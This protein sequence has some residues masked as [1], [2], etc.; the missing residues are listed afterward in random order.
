[1]AV[2]SQ[3]INERVGRGGGYLLGGDFVLRGP[4]PFLKRDQTVM[5][6]I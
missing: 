3:L 4:N 5:R 2:L 6:L 1:M